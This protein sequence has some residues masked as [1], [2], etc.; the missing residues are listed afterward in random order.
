M[1]LVQTGI[2]QIR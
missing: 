1:Q 2:A